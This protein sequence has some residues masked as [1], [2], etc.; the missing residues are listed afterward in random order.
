MKKKIILSSLLIGSVVSVLPISFVFNNKNYVARE[1]EKRPINEEIQ[2]ANILN[3][4]TRSD[5]N[6][7]QK[8]NYN[9]VYMNNLTRPVVSPNE[10]VPGVLGAY[11]TGDIG[12]FPTAIGWTAPNLFQ[13]WSVN[14]DAHPSLEGQTPTGFT[15]GLVT[16]LH[17]DT[18]YS[19]VKRNQ[20]FAIVANTANLE[21]KDYWILRYNALDGSPILDTNAKM[22]KMTN[23]P[24]PEL[25][26]ANGNGSAFALTNDTI[27]DR[28]ISFYPGRLGDLK[29][30]IFA[31]KITAD[32]KIEYQTNNGSFAG[33]SNWTSMS[34]ATSKIDYD[35]NNIVMG[36]T[37]FNTKTSNFEGSI[38]LML[39]TQEVGTN[40]N[41][42]VVSLKKDFGATDNFVSKP[43][44]TNSASQFG[45]AGEVINLPKSLLTLEKVQKYTNPHLQLFYYGS[46]ESHKVQMLLPIQKESEFIF[47][48]LSSISS[49]P[50]VENSYEENLGPNSH[51]GQGSFFSSPATTSNGHIPV[52]PSISF[53][54]LYP[55]EYIIN[56]QT[57]ASVPQS[58]TI[59]EITF[60]TTPSGP[61]NPATFT[62]T[63]YSVTKEEN[64][65]ARNTT[66][67]FP[68]FST[69][70]SYKK[71]NDLYLFSGLGG[72]GLTF[73]SDGETALSF[74]NLGKVSSGGIPHEKFQKV[75]SDLK[76]LKGQASAKIPSEITNEEL[77]KVGNKTGDFL[78]IP[79]VSYP[80]VTSWE[81]TTELEGQPIR[82]D[83]NGTIQGI[84][85]LIQKFSITEKGLNF[86]IQSRIPFKVTGLNTRSDIPTSISQNGSILANL[87]SELTPENISNFVD[88]IAAPTNAVV[89]NWNIT[90]LNNAAGTATVSADVIPHYGDDGIEVNTSRTFTTNVT[91]LETLTGTTVSKTSMSGANLTVWDVT[92]ENA[93][94]FIQVNNLIPGSSANSMTYAIKDQA[95]L[96]GTLTITTTIQAGSYYDP[97][98]KGL[99]S[100]AGGSPL[101]LD[102]PIDGFKKIPGSTIVTSRTGPFAG[103][104]PT[105]INEKNAG[106]FIDITNAV[107][108]S[109]YTIT[110]IDSSSAVGA[111][112]VT[113]DITFDKEYNTL[114]LIV[115]GSPKPIKVEGFEIGIP[116]Y[117]T[118]VFSTQNKTLFSN[119]LPPEINNSNVGQF[120]LLSNV[121]ADAIISY[122]FGTQNNVGA[123]NTGTQTISVTFSKFIDQNNITQDKSI[124]LPITITGLKT[125]PAPT[126]ITALSGISDT[127]PQF[128]SQVNIDKF[129]RINN[130]SPIPGKPTSIRID[131][132]SFVTDNINGTISFNYKIINSVQNFE[133][134]PE[135]RSFPLIVSGFQKGAVTNILG[136]GNI[137]NLKASEF[138]LDKTNFLQYAKF[139]GYTV[140]EVDEEGILTGTAV[141]SI[142]KTEFNDEKG[143]ATFVATVEGGTINREGVFNTDSIEI[144][145]TLEGF[146]VVVPVNNM[147]PIIIGSVGGGLG[148]IILLVV[149]IIVFNNI[150]NKKILEQ[151]KPVTKSG[152]PTPPGSARPSPTVTQSVT[153]PGMA[154]PA[155]PPAP[156][157]ARPVG[158]PPTP[159]MARPA[160]PPGMARPANPPA[161]GMGRP[162]APPR[163]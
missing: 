21:A 110:N 40:Y 30:D 33:H 111:G 121:P 69:I 81:I 62:L 147:L 84:L 24:L 127:L 159:G 26:E 105:F 80:A 140:S 44:T 70:D 163:R 25:T 114:G 82:D 85:N 3:E 11:K 113:F 31:L 64:W 6:V 18:I 16:A 123:P 88:V 130:T 78:F 10:V 51:L 42:R 94:G 161:P 148:F 143:T 103:I 139:T 99:P 104:Y 4:N 59:R 160:A 55:E 49:N 19:T 45:G 107:P 79:G 48:Y 36:L 68:Y 14:L 43:I 112:A 1:D 100:I 28:Y 7:F 22:P 76:W 71:Q 86:V 136:A 145:F 32:N 142:T 35:D 90:N 149:G 122:E 158:P 54:D 98:N 126:S 154:R 89:S 60:P 73:S 106:D 39:A 50:S 156:G 27:N 133:F 46:N 66:V 109:K 13:S 93:A 38:A 17:S 124:T 162:V 119:T 57:K 15:P 5:N 153:P 135:T 101:I 152:P 83:R 118:N 157:M 20:I 146:E 132:G 2:A 138:I 9:I 91:G 102:T 63:K 125:I 29:K 77:T 34:T 141:T 116:T 134:I 41:F 137:S 129:Y 151:K 97:S 144:T 87:P 52:A 56:S 95:P 47:M 65:K 61:W 53:N 96:N 8:L 128:I 120:L 155:A 131:E 58:Y 117:N 37:P 72:R 92:P 12:V 75:A 115:A 108:G 150:R 67:K 74:N 23:A